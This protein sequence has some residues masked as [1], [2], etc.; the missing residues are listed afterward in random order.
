MKMFHS[1]NEL[2]DYC[3]YCPICQ[4]YSREIEIIIGPEDIF[5]LTSYL[6]RGIYLDL[7][8]KSRSSDSVIHRYELIIDCISNTFTIV[9]SYDYSPDI[10]TFYVYLF[11]NCYECDAHVNTSDIDLD[12]NL[13]KLD[14][15]SLDQ[16]GISLTKTKDKYHILTDYNSKQMLVHKLYL[17]K[18]DKYNI[19]R[20]NTILPIVSL[21]YKNQ[22]NAVNKIKNLLIFS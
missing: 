18:D 8:V 7:R 17:S 1:F 19:S 3:L 20:K 15:L 16:E 9:K 5:C 10:D 21:D 22:T 2:W 4:D 12:F 13:L 14:Q 6:K 11:S